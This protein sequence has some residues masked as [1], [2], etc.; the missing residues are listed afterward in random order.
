MAKRII[1]SVIVL[2]IFLA[3]IIGL[4]EFKL[5][6]NRK[7]A[8]AIAHMPVPP[9]TVSTGIVRSDI[10]PQAIHIVGSLLRFKGC[11]CQPRFP[12]MSRPY[13]FIPAR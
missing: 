2:A 9:V 7:I 5:M 1:I 13:I 4:F 12:A 10:V 8:Y 6:V 11:R 3:V